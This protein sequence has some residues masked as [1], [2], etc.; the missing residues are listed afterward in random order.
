[1]AALYD[2][3]YTLSFCK[4][5]GCGYKSTLPYPLIIHNAD[6]DVRV[7]ITPLGKKVITITWCNG[8]MNRDEAHQN[9]Q[10]YECPDCWIDGLCPRQEEYDCRTQEEAF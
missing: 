6:G 10:D 5:K 2:K 4:N 3:G 9:C 7:D 8:G 1:M